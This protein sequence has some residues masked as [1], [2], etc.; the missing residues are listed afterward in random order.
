MV[1]V[2]LATYNGEKYLPALLDSLFS[3]TYRDFRVVIRDDLSTDNTL[4]IINNYKEIYGDSIVICDTDCKSYGAAQNFFKML[5]IYSDDY[6]MFCDQDD[7]WLPTKIEKTLAKMQECEKIYGKDMPLLVHTDLYVVDENLSVISDSFIKYQKLSPNQ[8]SINKIIVQNTVTGCTMM[9]NRSLSE[10]IYNIPSGVLHDWWI[11]V[12][13]SAIGKIVY[14]DTP[15]I[16]YRQHGK[17]EVGAQNAAGVGFI[18]KKLKNYDKQKQIYALTPVMAEILLMDYG[19]LL[20]RENTKMLNVLAKFPSLNK[21][22][23]IRMINKYDLKK[24]TFLRII[25]Q[26]LYM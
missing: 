18:I 22:E 24:N 15:L 21:T 23:K 5:Q 26:Y 8:N 9:I 7:I 3:Q 16:K 20:S 25:S 19:Q 11:A 4:Q 1:T 13:A 17:N 6:I 12:V 2:L 10:K 14:L